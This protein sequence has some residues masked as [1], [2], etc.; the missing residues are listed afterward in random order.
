M[1]QKLTGLAVAGLCLDTAGAQAQPISTGAAPTY[2]QRL[3]GGGPM[4]TAVVGGEA[5]W[6][7]MARMIRADYATIGKVVK[8]AGNR[9]E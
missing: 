8:A 1:L 6:A 3:K 4:T 7:I 5:Q 9:P 2:P